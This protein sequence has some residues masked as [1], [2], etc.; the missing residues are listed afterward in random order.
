MAALVPVLFMVSVVTFA[1]N[2]L[3]PGDPALAYIG[4]ANISDK[5]MY[6]AVRQELGLDQPIPV[7]YIRWL[8]RAVRGD[9]GRSIRTREPA[10]DGLIARLPITLQL[11]VMAM[12][13][14]LVIAIPVGIISAVKP[15]S[16]LDTAGTVLAMTGAAV[17]DFWLAILMIYFFAVWLRLVP[18]SGYV[19]LDQGLWLNLQSMILPSVA[20]GM[21]L[22]AV[23]MRQ[24]RAS[25]IEVL[26]QEYVVVARAK[27][28][29]E[30]NIIGR[31]AL[32]N[33]LIP[34]VTVLGLQTGRLFGGAVLIETIFSL[35]G[36]GRLATD[37]IL[38][39]DYPMLLG[40]VL[41]LALSVML[42]SLVTDVLYAVLDPRIRYT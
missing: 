25:L 11:S 19:P 12:V 28:L 34:M 32:K 6:E 27:G 4:E 15:N 9:F 7:Q 10:L 8:S 30:R 33:A 42:A 17:P 23:V 5:V 18:S 40:V 31:H 39:R 3:L 41:I 22:S 13:I 20:L 29:R 2:L 14:S 38:F 35:P 37:S 26:R 36:L 16:T 21:V 1:V 24:L